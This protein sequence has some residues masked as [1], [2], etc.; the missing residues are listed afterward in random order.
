MF[1]VDLVWYFFWFCCRATYFVDFVLLSTI[2]GETKK[3]N[4][5]AQNLDDDFALDEL[6][7]D[8]DGIVMMEFEKMLLVSGERVE[9]GL[10]F[11]NC[12]M[13]LNLL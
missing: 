12:R 10:H 2:L 13:L 11:D 1:V 3:E 8:L 4:Q 6:F 7:D 5:I 9:K